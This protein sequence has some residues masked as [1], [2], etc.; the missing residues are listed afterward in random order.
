MK[1]TPKEMQ[2]VLDYIQQIPVSENS[3]AKMAVLDNLMKYHSELSDE[4]KEAFPDEL[5]ADLRFED[6]RATV[7][8]F[9]KDKQL[10]LLKNFVID[11]LDLSYYRDAPPFYRAGYAI[12]N[13]V[14][15]QDIIDSTPK[16][17]EDERDLWIYRGLNA[18][19]LA[20]DLFVRM[21]DQEGTFSALKIKA[22]ILRNKSYK[23]AAEIVLQGIRQAPNEEWQQT[24][25]ELW[26]EI[27]NERFDLFFDPK[28][29]S[30]INQ[31]PLPKDT[32]EEMCKEDPHIGMFA[33]KCLC[34]VEPSYDRS[35]I[36]FV[37]K[38]DD[39]STPEVGE[40]SEIAKY[41]F[42]ID[43]IPPEIHF[44]EGHPKTNTLYEVDEEDTTL[45]HELK[46]DEQ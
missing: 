5:V 2:D 44:D 38:I 4:E 39:V 33:D 17:Q 46:E 14:A 42:C 26:N 15:C 3:F 13:A 41:V 18:I 1:I 24:F 27:T 20:I 8:S 37:E 45:Y 43:R 35:L 12:L 22:D 28:E 10:Q 19:N 32:I 31:L 7:E 9:S 29:K 21:D 25:V 16:D 40:L 23:E 11:D 6:F 30:F 34:S 36:L